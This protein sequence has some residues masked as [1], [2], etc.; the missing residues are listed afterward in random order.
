MGF[1]IG[2]GFGADIGIKIGKNEK[3][4][5]KQ[6]PSAFRSDD[7]ATSVFGQVKKGKS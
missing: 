7:E 5:E 3:G 1:L 6:C 2:L 4:R